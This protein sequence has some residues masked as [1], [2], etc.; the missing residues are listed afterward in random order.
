MK[1]MLLLSRSKVIIMDQFQ[2]ILN[3]YLAGKQPN[4]SVYPQAMQNA[5]N[6]TA[7]QNALQP[8]QNIMPQTSQSNSM[9]MQPIQPSNQPQSE[10]LYNDEYLNAILQKFV[11]QK[12]VVEFLIGTNTLLDRS[13]YL[14]EV[15]ANYLILNE[16]E[17]D[18]LLVCDFYSVKF[19]R[20]YL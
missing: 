3:Q 7:A 15:G 8:Y 20:V 6:Q 9:M 14:L 4:S 5:A 18:D 1:G 19:V 10:M 11:G 17:T 12:V 16:L 2:D 13:G